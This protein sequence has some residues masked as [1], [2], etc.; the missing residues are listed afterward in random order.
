HTV[1]LPSASGKVLSSNPHVAAFGNA[2][3]TRNDNS[4]RFGKYIEIGFDKRY[5]V[6]GANMRTY[7]MEKSRVV[8]QAEDERNYHI[9]YQLCALSGLEEFRDLRLT[10][11]EDFFYTCQGGDTC[12]DGV[13]DAA[14]FKKTRHAF[15]LLGVNK[16][17]EMTIFR[18]IAAILHL[19]NLEIQEEHGGE[20]CHVLSENEHLNIFCNLMG[21]EHSQMKHWLC[22][23][24]LVT[25][26]E[27]YVK[28]MTRPEVENARD[29]LAKHIYAQLFK[30]IV[31]RINKALHTSVKQQ[32]FIGVLDIYGFEM[33]EQNSFEQFCINYANEKLQ[34]QFNLHVFKLEQD[35]Y[36]KEEIPW[37]FID[38]YDNQPC[39]DLIET[40]LGILDLLDEECKMPKG[41]DRNWTQKLYNRHTGSPHFQKPRA[42]GTSFI[43]LHFADKVKYESIGF[44]EKNRDTVHEEQIDILKTSK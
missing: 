38:F 33:F 43:I 42:S 34:Q 40:K 30:W 44:L 37:T 5:H 10:C 13:D 28:N 35:E 15:T 2:R 6:S 36:M 12:I 8:F 29:A 3:T 25:A 4:S 22:H 23:R 27:T 31:Q 14:D 24:K 32:S 16:S 26:S 20:S 21:V 39:I 9:F 17:H 11:A 1:A 19:G 41:T 18:I 7:L